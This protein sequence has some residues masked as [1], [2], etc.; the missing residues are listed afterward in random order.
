MVLAGDRSGSLPWGGLDDR[1]RSA[2][3]RRGSGGVLLV[4]FSR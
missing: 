3:A 2:V 4:I 1:E